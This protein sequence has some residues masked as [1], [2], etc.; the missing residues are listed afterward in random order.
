MAK[1][2]AIYNP[3]DK[4]VDDLPLI[5]GFNNG[6]GGDLWHAQLLAQDGTAL[7]NHICSHEGFM[8]GDLGLVPGSRPDRHETFQKHYP[9]GYRMDFVS[10]D[11]VPSHVGL[12]E[13]F[14]LNKEQAAA[15]R[16]TSHEQA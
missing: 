16:E 6:G 13:A 10:Y 11:D 3:H 9:D 5:Y 4:P 8:P 1:E 2:Y 12:K 7:G 15:A 14:R